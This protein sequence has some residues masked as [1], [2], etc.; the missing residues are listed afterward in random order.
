MAPFANGSRC[1]FP[2]CRSSFAADFLPLYPKCP[3]PFATLGHLPPLTFAALDICLPGTN[4]TFN[5]HPKNGIFASWLLPP[6]TF[7]VLGHLPLWDICHPETFA[8]LRHLPFWHNFTEIG[9]KWHLYQRGK[10]HPGDIC[11]FETFAILKIIFL[12]FELRP[13]PP[14]DIC[15]FV[16]FAAL[17]LLPFCDTCL[18]R[19]F[20]LSGHLLLQ[21]WIIVIREALGITLIY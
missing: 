13:M 18:F 9:W 10:C 3:F 19:T 16:T 1:R 15:R 8:T 11:R 5:Q 20:A 7:A 4:A 12:P 2:E 14:W 21:N 6:E 17:W